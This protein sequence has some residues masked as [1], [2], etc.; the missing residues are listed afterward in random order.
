MASLWP[1]SLASA[2][3]PA[4]ANEPAAIRVAPPAPVFDDV[5][6]LAELA[7]R[8]A[9]V[10]EK[11]GP[12][13]IL[14]MFSAEPRVYTNDVDYEFRQE[15][16]L[17]Y[18][19]NLK[20]QG[21]TLVLMPGNASMREVLFLPRRDPSKET[22][23]GHMYG[24][25]EARRV[26]GVS[27]I[28]DAKEF[29]PFMLAIRT[30]RAY[31]P[32]GDRVLASAMNASAPS[33]GTTQPVT[34]PVPKSDQTTAAAS[35]ATP[36]RPVNGNAPA[37][38]VTQ[39]APSR[40]STPAA[41]A[42][43]TPVNVNAPAASAPAG[44]ESLFAAMMQSDAQLYLLLPGGED[45]REYRQ[46]QDFA[47]KWARSAIGLNVR[48]AWPI[49]VEMRMRKSP[50]ELQLLQHAIDISIEGHERAQAFA[51]RAKWEYEVEAEI[52]Y[53]FKRR[54][55][56]NWGYPNI[57]G[58]GPNGTTLHYE[59]SQS[60]VRPNDLILI[61][62][63][64]EYGHYTADVTRTFPVSG[65]FNPA[66][67]DIY[68][69]VLAAQEASFKAIRV[70]SS[71][72]EVHNASVEV[73]KDSLLRLGLITDRNSDQYRIWFM[74]G[75]SHWLGMNV[76]DVGVRAAKLDTGMVFTVE[77]GVYIREDALDYLP[78]TPENRKFIAAVRPAF[79]KYKGIGVRIED[80][81]VVTTDG[82]RNLS[83][84]LPRT[85]QDIEAFMARARKESRVAAWREDGVRTTASLNDVFVE[86]VSA[87]TPGSNST[88]F[89]RQH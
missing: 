18:L 38:M 49:F 66:Q 47:A 24:P 30:R 74:H 88:R 36:A 42:G 43:A 14:V 28:W 46:E 76:H 33:S 80:D 60:Q 22:W 44:F 8:R 83:G 72:P 67:S 52:D 27:E 34:P 78:D 63:G 26:S 15:N 40:D 73:I 35:A 51:A 70:G 75:T 69:V 71:L 53:T 58:C 41:A 45:S 31:R 61:D 5:A 65:K 81:V 39:N 82:Y 79:E 9:R 77:P 10:A 12:K 4:R 64:A 23:T 89:L 84:A 48:T 59:E 29:E 55:A 6:R 2:T 68:N 7:A 17:Y 11:I 62:S 21:A 37:N 54:N 56:D 32:Q 85:I 16:N 50:S 1:A 87:L 57:V 86:R 3:A 19:T 25:E 20:Q 13:A